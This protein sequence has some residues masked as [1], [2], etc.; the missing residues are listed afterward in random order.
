M[1]VKFQLAIQGGGAR[2]A[3]LLV[4]AEVIQHFETQGRIT[5][6]KIA[7]TSAGS[8]VG[9]LL[10]I[11]KRESI[12]KAR[13]YLERHADAIADVIVPPGSTD[14][15]VRT[16][17]KLYK[18]QAICGG[19]SIRQELLKL[20]QNVFG[21]Q[22]GFFFKDLDKE[23]I[24]IAADV[25]N[26]SKHSYSAPNENL[27]EALLN[28]CAIPLVFRGASEMQSNPYVDGGLCE[29]LPSAEL[30]KD[31]K[32]FGEV[33]ALSFPDHADGIAPTK[34]LRFI[35]ELFSTAINNSVQRATTQLPQNAVLSIPS[36]RST[37]Q[38]KGAFNGNVRSAEFE[39]IVR[40]TTEWLERNLDAKGRPPVYRNNEAAEHLM[41]ELYDWYEA[42][43]AKH[44]RR[45]IR[46]VLVVK[47]N[48]LVQG[49]NPRTTADQIQKIYHFAPIEVPMNCMLIGIGIEEQ[50]S[51][52]RHRIKVRAPDGD[53]VKTRLVPV[54]D[55]IE[56]DYEGYLVLFEPALPP[57]KDEEIRAKGPY[58]AFY[59]AA[60]TGGMA[61]LVLKGEDDITNKNSRAETI[62]RVEIV[63]FAPENFSYYPIPT[64][65]IKE[66]RQ[67][68]G[69]FD[70]TEQEIGNS[71]GDAQL[72]F[73]VSGWRT[74][75]FVTGSKLRIGLVKR[76]A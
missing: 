17:W 56:G 70:M 52:L 68:G 57:M 71:V 15:N 55:R 5:I 62:E 26:R 32:S 58:K 20:F 12:K 67:A 43:Q 49:V 75:N 50:Q 2:I 39:V 54:I 4:A 37:L 7:G 10:A 21:R 30:S 25:V 29:N 48:S 1:P 33:I 63:F 59:E 53:E 8:I 23:M 46:N 69:V 11:E 6:T 44:P 31:T 73:R 47:A 40:R 42:T 45:S 65:S 34:T 61:N 76:G 24:V 74:D 16:V 38:F 66:V 18:N 27:I 64:L 35:Y 19:A 9:A 22:T 13:E 36:Q 28:S 3:E 14:L 41:G 72:G 51:F 60:I